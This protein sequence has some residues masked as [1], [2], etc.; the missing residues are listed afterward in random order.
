MRICFDLDGVICEL[1]RDGQS[2]AD[3]EP[4]PGAVEKLRSL[5]SVGHTIII[6]TGRHMRTCGGNVGLVLARQG[7]ITLEWLNRHGVPFDELY[8]GKPWAHVYVDDNALRFNSWDEIDDHG[9]NLPEQ[10]EKAEGLVRELI[11]A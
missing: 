1:R 10:H 5:K 3:L 2:Y 9:G 8:F 7:H 11:S 6:C 4:V